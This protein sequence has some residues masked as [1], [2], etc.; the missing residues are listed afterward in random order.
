[1]KSASFL[2]HYNAWSKDLYREI[3]TELPDAVD[4]REKGLLMLYRTE[5]A[6]KEEEETADLARKMGIKAEVLDPGRINQLNPE[7]DI[8]VIGGVFYPDDAQVYSNR[9]MA[10]MYD[11]LGKHKV[12][13]IKDTEV[14]DLKVA[15]GKID[16]IVTSKNRDIKV[17]HLVI[18]AGAW[19]TQL[20]KKIGIKLLQQ[21]GKG[22][23]ITTQPPARPSI[24]CILTGAKVAMTPM[25]NE[26]RITG[27]LEISNLSRNINLKRVKGF[28]S[29][30]R[31]YFP[32]IKINSNP[33]PDQIWTGY[34][35]CSPDGI[36]YLGK[37]KK[38][39]NLIIATGHA[40]M[41]MSLG[42]A[43]GRLISQILCNDESELDLKVLSPDRTFGT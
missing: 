6:R 39:D 24:P 42:P 36:P 30:V 2:H 34:R 15:N 35:P 10:A 26:L 11:H 19:S 20:L 18:S 38:Y 12:R 43:S 41:G 40:M 16:K 17:D 29:A 9:F 7:V 23:S 3:C 37:S 22:Y 31:K 1:M 21:D 27:T 32:E 25:G 33:S 4:F 8:D 14:E 13:F 28:L 5:S